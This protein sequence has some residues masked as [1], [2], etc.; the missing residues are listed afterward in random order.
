MKFFN[1]LPLNAKAVRLNELLLC[2][3]CRKFLKTDF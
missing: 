3:I 2:L 1:L